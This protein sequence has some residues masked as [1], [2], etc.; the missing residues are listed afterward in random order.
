MTIFYPD[1]YSGQAGMSFSGTR[2][3]MVKATQGTGY[4]NPDYAAAKGRAAS[5]SSYFAAYHF[6]QQGNGSG[7]AQHCFSVVG[8]GIPL[9]LDFE[10]TSGSSPTIGDATSFVDAYRSLGGILYLNY[11]PMWYWEQLGS[12]SSAPLIS[13]NLTVVSSDYTTYSD[14]GPGWAAYGGMVPGVWQYTSTASF[15]GFNPVDF[16]AYKG[17]TQQ[18]IGMANGLPSYGSQGPA[19]T[20]VQTLLNQHGAN[21]QLAQDGVFGPGTS[22]A[23]QAFQQSHG[24]TVD[25]VC[26]PV[27]M[28]ALQ[29]TTP[30]PPD[31]PHLPEDTLIR[32][33]EKTYAISFG[34]SQYSWIAFFCDNTV[35]GQPTQ[36]LR[37]APW[38]ADTGFTG[39]TSINVDSSHEKVT[40]PLPAHCAGISIQRQNPQGTWVPIAYNL[41]A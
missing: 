36:Q 21:P 28:A 24:L 9:M 35:E 6:L 17:T 27:T 5:A 16:N 4:T 40:V 22:A 15:N 19:V 26:G 14:S 41:G 2:I 7:Q 31:Q 37:V 13:R 12:P 18:W 32:A 3:A 33:D 29:L 25:G 30:P 8:K 39:I 34:N 38:S 1:I 23:V 20:K 11:F 10:P